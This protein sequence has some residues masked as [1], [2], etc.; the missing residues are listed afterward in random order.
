M[1]R[2]G[3]T[4]FARFDDEGIATRMRAMQRI[5]ERPELGALVGAAIAG[6]D[7]FPA[8]VFSDAFYETI[9]AP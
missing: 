9:F 1:T 2:F 6:P 8:E 5:G 4:L 7:A 3:A